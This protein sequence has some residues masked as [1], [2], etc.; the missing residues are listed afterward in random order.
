MTPPFGTQISV[1]LADATKQSDVQEI[2]QA[3]GRQP[4]S[5]TE[6]SSRPSKEGLVEEGDK[7]FRKIAAAGMEQYGR[8]REE[9]PEIIEQEATSKKVKQEGQ[10]RTYRTA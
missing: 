3:T 7:V 9:S 4:K 10:A 8:I 5:I 1:F 2:A 6:A